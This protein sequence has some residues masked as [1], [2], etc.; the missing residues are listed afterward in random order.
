MN[1]NLMTALFCVNSDMRLDYRLIPRCIDIRF[2]KISINRDR[3]CNHIMIE[4]C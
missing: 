2:I 1:K 3:R 4:Y